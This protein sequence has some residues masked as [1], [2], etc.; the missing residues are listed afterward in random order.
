MP[1]ADLR[2]ERRVGLRCGQS[3]FEIAFCL[4]KSYSF[5]FLIKIPT[6]DP[7]DPLM[8]QRSRTIHTSDQSCGRQIVARC[9]LVF[10]CRSLRGS[11]RWR[12]S[13]HPDHIG[14]SLRTCVRLLGAMPFLAVCFSI[15]NPPV[16]FLVVSYGI[17]QVLQG[18][19][20]RLDDAVHRQ[21]CSHCCN[22]V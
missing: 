21:V 13:A 7:A 20:K 11:V 18:A 14:I 2:I 5:G 16:R 19:A 9:A 3:Y 15:C 8:I 12:P 17:V 10:R 1:L 6:P 22:A 4:S